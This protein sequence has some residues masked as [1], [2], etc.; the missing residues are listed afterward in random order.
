MNGPPLEEVSYVQGQLD[1]ALNIIAKQ[2]GEI[3]NLQN[4]ISEQQ[5]DIKHLKAEIIKLRHE[6]QC[7]KKMNESKGDSL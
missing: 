4:R 6:L 7:Q 5:F 1:M 2:N 3:A